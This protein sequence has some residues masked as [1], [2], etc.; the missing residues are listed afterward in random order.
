VLYLV[1]QYQVFTESSKGFN[2]GEQGFVRLR[3]PV[4]FG[5]H[6]FASDLRRRTVQ[7]DTKTS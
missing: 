7:N 5:H 3:T 4:I 6:D 1:L 2:Q